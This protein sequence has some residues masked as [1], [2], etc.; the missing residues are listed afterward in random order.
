MPMSHS[1][2]RLTA[3]GRAAIVALAVVMVRVADA[4][5]ADDAA[6]ATRLAELLRPGE[7]SCPITRR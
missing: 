1:R 7:T 4:G 5:D 6:M 2:A 3:A